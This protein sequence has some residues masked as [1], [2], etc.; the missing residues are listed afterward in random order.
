[1]WRSGYEIAVN[2][3]SRLGRIAVA[4]LSSSWR[5]L[6]LIAPLLPI[7][8]IGVLFAGR[9]NGAD[10]KNLDQLRRP[11]A[12]RP[13]SAATPARRCARARTSATR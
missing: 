1:M 11:A 10:L 4:L 13:R 5:F 8:E 9:V 12:G 2:R 3:G 6:V 7:Y